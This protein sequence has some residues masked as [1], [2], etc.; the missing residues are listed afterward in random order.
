[1]AKGIRK[2]VSIP[3]LLAPALRLRMRE[4]GHRTVSPFAVDLVCY[5]LRSGAPHAITLAISHDT[6]AA[7]DAVDAELVARYRPGQTRNGLLVEFVEHLAKL[8]E[9]ARHT[10]SPPPPLNAKPERIM[11]PAVIWPLA[12][13]RWRELGYETLSAYITGLL[14]YDLLIGGPH[15]FDAGDARREIKSA[16]DQE[17]RK[18]RESG[19]ARKLFLDYLIERAHGK[20]FSKVELEQKKEEIADRLLKHVRHPSMRQT[21]TVMLMK[22]P[23]SVAS[24]FD[25]TANAAI[26]VCIDCRE[27]SISMSSSL[28]AWASPRRLLPPPHCEEM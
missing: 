10:V 16:L 18:T 14:R 19:H 12:D 6:Q 24:L 9:F 2:N 4:F 25:A 7:Q 27:A 11:L 15:S 26:D 13:L 23:D 8:R 5:D 1:M 22:V 3:G 28:D 20:E 21:G 17:T